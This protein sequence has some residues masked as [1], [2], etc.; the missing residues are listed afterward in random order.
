MSLVT[1]EFLLSEL[2]RYYEIY[3]KIP[4]GKELS[5]N[6]NFPSPGIYRYRF[7]KLSNA[8]DLAGLK[9]DKKIQVDRNSKE[10]IYK[11]IIDDYNSGIPTNEIAKR[12]GYSSNCSISNIIKKFNVEKRLNRWSDEEIKFLTDYY[13]LTSSTE[14]AERLNRKKDDVLQKAH[15]L[16]LKRN[17]YYWTE[18]EITVLR[19]NYNLLKPKELA[20]L[21]NR[22]PRT[23]TTKAIKLGLTENKN[24]TVEEDEQLKSLHSSL[25]NEEIAEIIGRSRNSVVCR[26]SILNLK[27]SKE[28]W[29]S[30]KCFSEDD[31]LLKLIELYNILQRTPTQLDLKNHKDYPSSATY[32]RYFGSYA[33]ACIKAGLEVNNQ[34][35]GHSHTCLSKNN[36]LCLSKSEKII[37]DIF[38]DNNTKYEKETLYSNVISDDKCGLRRM[39]WLI[40]NNI[41]V[42]Y[43][44]MPDK[45]HY[46]LRMNNKI[47][48]CQTHNIT[49]VQLYKEDIV[50]KNKTGLVNKF[51]AVG[52]KLSV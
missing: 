1:N 33:K 13:P 41:I 8:I 38:I 20:K 34:L 44:G 9:S 51:K 4:A 32:R 26:S 17:N 12:F 42:E 25:P 3:N 48:L 52:I 28:Y 22:T 5:T 49:L 43:F 18:H 46:L 39:D 16:G 10:E 45:D 23:I 15:N 11:M 29:D 50:S 47:E 14:I 36:D 24:W 40:N 2:R 21:L 37:T 31:L 7:G 19:N 35:F 27:K 30:L 6:E